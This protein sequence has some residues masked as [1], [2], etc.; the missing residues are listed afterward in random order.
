MTAEWDTFTS[1]QQFEAATDE[2]EK[3]QSRQQ[4]N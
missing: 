3:Q 1:L 4:M 2:E